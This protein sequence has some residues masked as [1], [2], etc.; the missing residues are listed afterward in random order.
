MFR[1]GD[2]TILFPYFLNLHQHVESLN[3]LYNPVVAMINHSQLIL[4]C[5]FKHVRALH[6]AH[7]HS[8]RRAVRFCELRVYPVTICFFAKCATVRSCAQTGHIFEPVRRR[9][10]ALR[11]NACPSWYGHRRAR[12]I[13]MIESDRDLAGS[14]DRPVTMSIDRYVMNVILQLAV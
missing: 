4:L 10:F 8:A 9:G 5:I 11:L 2:A 6:L 14:L 13:E 12:P 3:I 1:R 7:S